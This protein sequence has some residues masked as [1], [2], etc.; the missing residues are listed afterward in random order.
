[1]SALN[2]HIA[3]TMALFRIGWDSARQDKVTRIALATVYVGLIVVLTGLYRMTPFD[4]LTGADHLRFQTVVWYMTIT[5]LVAI[6]VWTQYREVREEV[7]A[8]QI[9]SRFILPLSYYRLKF[10]EWLGRTCRSMMEF[11]ILG[12]I[13]AFLLT[14]EFVLAPSA[15]PGLAISLLLSVI[16]FNN[17]HLI[18]GLLEVWGAHSRPAFLIMQKLLFLLGG[19]LI[20][21]DIYP[22]WLQ[23]LAWATPFPAIL[24]G[25]ASFAFGKSGEEALT[26]IG[27]QIFWLLVTFIAALIVFRTARN[28]IGRDGD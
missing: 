16:L 23:K 12:T 14:G 13:V 21:L 1:M 22:A 28:K 7:L 2:L 27:I 8:H 19:L 20:P 24:Y 9:A 10:G 17:L 25:P 5:E 11:A 15:L 6:A 18:I 4:Q 26:L 3:P